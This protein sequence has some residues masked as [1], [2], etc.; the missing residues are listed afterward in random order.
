M[1]HVPQKSCKNRLPWCHHKDFPTNGI[2]RIDI[3]CNTDVMRCVAPTE[4]PERR[5]DGHRAGSG[6]STIP[7]QVTLGAGLLFM[8]PRRDVSIDVPGKLKF[9]SL[10]PASSWTSPRPRA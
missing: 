8:F 5:G 3:L 4:M 10:T 9:S 7:T 1:Q 2:R 6:F